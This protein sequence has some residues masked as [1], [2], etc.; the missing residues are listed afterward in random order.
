MYLILIFIHKMASEVKYTGY[1][2]IRGVALNIRYTM[3]I[4]I[5]KEIRLIINS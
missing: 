5:L 1:Q 3:F 4:V 2:R